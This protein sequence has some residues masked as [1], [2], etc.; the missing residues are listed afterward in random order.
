MEFI[1]LPLIVLVRAGACTLYRDRIAEFL[2]HVA[3]CIRL[4]AS[5]RL[6]H[7][8]DYDAQTQR[9]LSTYLVAHKTFMSRR[10]RN[11]VFEVAVTTLPPVERRKVQEYGRVA[12]LSFYLIIPSYLTNEQ[13]LL[14]S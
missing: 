13:E 12:T 11:P 6:L 4:A 10:A 7:P 1:C 8:N 5:V 14:R 2:T 9:R 3:V